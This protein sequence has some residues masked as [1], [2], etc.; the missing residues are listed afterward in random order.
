MLPR[1]A[2]SPPEDIIMRFGLH[3]GTTL[4]L[5]PIATSGRAEVRALGDETC[6][7][8]ERAPASK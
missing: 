1:T 4:H 6:A 8:A 5:G 7:T 2:N 3:W